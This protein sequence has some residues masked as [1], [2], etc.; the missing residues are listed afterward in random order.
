MRKNEAEERVGPDDAFPC[1]PKSLCH[2]SIMCLD[3][4][5]LRENSG[6]AYLDMTSVERDLSGGLGHGGT[7]E[8][9]LRAGCCF[10]WPTAFLLTEH[11]ISLSFIRLYF[12]L[13]FPPCCFKG[14]GQVWVS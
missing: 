14:D 3:M 5:S 1:D 9:E 8:E 13:S 11:F 2:M 6:L 4:L 12:T 10:S 7:P